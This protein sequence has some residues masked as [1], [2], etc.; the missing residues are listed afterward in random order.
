MG[1]IHPGAGSAPA[2]G[3]SSPP[4]NASS[5]IS[6]TSRVVSSAM[7]QSAFNRGSTVAAKK[8]A[9]A[10]LLCPQLGEALEVVAIAYR[11]A[12]RSP[13]AANRINGLVSVGGT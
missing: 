4:K 5:G 7:R 3:R 10:T 6:M 2:G 9:A 12:F 11:E 13:I 8:R 1:F